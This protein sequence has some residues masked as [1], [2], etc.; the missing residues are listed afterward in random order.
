[1]SNAPRIGR[2]LVG[3]VAGATA[4]WMSFVLLH[5]VFVARSELRRGEFHELNLQFALVVT[6]LGA[7]CGAALAYASVRMSRRVELIAKGAL[8]GVIVVVLL[9]LV[10]STFFPPKQSEQVKGLWF[11]YGVLPGILIGGAVG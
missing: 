5:D 1:M 3:F 4:G 6:I 9:G 11:D 2:M 7:C 8:G 10:S